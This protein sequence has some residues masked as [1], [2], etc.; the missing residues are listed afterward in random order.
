MSDRANYARPVTARIDEP[1]YTA[2]PEAP[3][4]TNAC[5]AG[6]PAINSPYTTAVVALP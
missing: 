1:A 5:P 6:Q 4:S 3:E 2:L